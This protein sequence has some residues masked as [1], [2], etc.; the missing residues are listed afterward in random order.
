MSALS[1]DTSN[2][3]LRRLPPKLKVSFPGFQPVEINIEQ[4]LKEL[5][6]VSTLSLETEEAYMVPHGAANSA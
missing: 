6:S 3:K 4:L 1:L 2:G 5:V